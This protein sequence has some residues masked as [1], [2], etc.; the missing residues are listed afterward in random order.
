MV[1]RQERQLK[2]RDQRIEDQ[3]QEHAKER[4]A[5]AL[6]LDEVN[7]SMQKLL[8]APEDMKPRKKLFGIF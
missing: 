3:Q 8:P 2:E 6:K 5:W 7:N 4:N 1:E